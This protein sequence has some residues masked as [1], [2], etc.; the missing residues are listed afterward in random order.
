MCPVTLALVPKVSVFVTFLESTFKVVKGASVSLAS[1]KGR[2]EGKAI[3][4]NLMVKTQYYL[5]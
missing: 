1:Y 2:Q 3:I 5:L 4:L